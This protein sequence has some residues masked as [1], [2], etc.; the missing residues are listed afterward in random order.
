VDQPPD[1][2]PFR[3]RIAVVELEDDRIRFAAIDAWVY[4]EVIGDE[5]AIALPVDRRP[6]LGPGDVRSGV[7]PVVL[8]AVFAAARSAVGPVHSSRGVLERELDQQ[9][10]D[11]AAR[12]N[13]ESCGIGHGDTRDRGCG[14]FSAPNGSLEH[15]FYQESRESQAKTGEIAIVHGGTPGASA[16]IE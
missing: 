1:L 7:L 16:S 6:H 15:M 3:S 10:R 11:M 2:S 13:A 4:R 12:A 14:P 8:L 5:L 9:L